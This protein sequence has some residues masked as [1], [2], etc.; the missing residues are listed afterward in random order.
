LAAAEARIAATEQLAERQRKASDAAIAS[1]QAELQAVHA[2]ATGMEQAALRN[3]PSRN[4][5][6]ALLEQKASL[7]GLDLSGLSLSSVDFGSAQLVSTNLENTDL[8]DAV[9]RGANLKYAKLAGA[10]LT[11]ADMRESQLH[12]AIGLGE[13]RFDDHV[14]LKGAQHTF[15]LIGAEPTNGDVVVIH[16]TLCRWKKGSLAKKKIFFGEGWDL[17]WPRELGIFSPA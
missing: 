8:S 17:Q 3:K 15:E 1:L 16:S 13:A 14:L 4:L 10:N 6:L 5:V 2:M 9:L 11:G 7:S 12:G